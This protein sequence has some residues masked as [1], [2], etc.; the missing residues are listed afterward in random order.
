MFKSQGL[1]TD[2][3]D[4][5]IILLNKGLEWAGGPSSKIPSEL[6]GLSRLQDLLSVG[7]LV[8]E[9]NFDGKAAHETVH[10]CYSSGMLDNLRHPQ[11]LS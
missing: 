10:M 4:K 3:A 1:T 6:L 7:T 8:E 11:F 2:E 5:R 9:E